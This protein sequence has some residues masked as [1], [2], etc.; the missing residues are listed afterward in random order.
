[1]DQVKGYVAT[2]TILQ[3]GVQETNQCKCPL[4][5]FSTYNN[6]ENFDLSENINKINFK[7]LTK[8]NGPCRTKKGKKI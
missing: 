5:Y 8:H 6:D 2:Q 3:N 4:K 7:M 1:M